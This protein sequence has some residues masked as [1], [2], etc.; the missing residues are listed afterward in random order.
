MP[1]Q[2]GPVDRNLVYGGHIREL[3]PPEAA[4]YLV[5][6]CVSDAQGL[7]YYSDRRLSELLGIPKPLVAAA[8]DGLIHNG[9]VLYRRPIYQLLEV[10]QPS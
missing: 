10:P 6:I 3:S 8:R 9:L 2:F 5:L 4:L 1:P 7:S